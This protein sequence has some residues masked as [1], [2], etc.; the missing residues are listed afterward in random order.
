MP[1]E[2]IKRDCKQSDGSSGAYV[3][4]KEKGDGSTEQSSCHTSK[5]KAQ[6]SVAARKMR[7]RRKMATKK[8]NRDNDRVLKEYV[9]EV[10][11]TDYVSMKPVVESREEALLRQWVRGTIS[12]SENLKSVAASEGLLSSIAWP[13]QKQLDEEWRL[14]CAYTRNPYL[15][16]ESS[17]IRAELLI[18]E[19]WDSF[20]D[21]AKSAGAKIGSLG[22]HVK[23]MG[24]DAS[25]YTQV[26]ADFDLVI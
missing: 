4:L 22:N 15:L 17:C 25:H 1:W 2:V 16:S 24:K 13:D 3:V 14:M 5:K 9:R 20:K 19:S 6:G 26:L 23:K 18:Q 8:I 10:V 12:M 11:R 7:E 21:L